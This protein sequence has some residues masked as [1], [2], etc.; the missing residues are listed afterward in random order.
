[1]VMSQLTWTS[2]REPSETQAT[3]S[4]NSGCPHRNSHQ[5]GLDH[6][7]LGLRRRSLPPS[8]IPPAGTHHA[9][10]TCQPAWLPDTR[11]SERE[12]SPLF[13]PTG[14]RGGRKESL[15]RARG[16]RPLQEEPAAHRPRLLLPSAESHA[17][18]PCLPTGARKRLHKIWIGLHKAW[19]VRKG[20][21]GFCV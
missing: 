16:A 15:P 18:G 10:V 8:L 12:G 3:V 21:G 2:A 1:M 6:V 20:W 19:L 13:L 4:L 9:A 14:S 17:C 11:R 7:L 5:D